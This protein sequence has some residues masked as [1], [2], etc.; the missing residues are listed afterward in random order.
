[1]SLGK[2]YARAVFKTTSSAARRT[3]RMMELTLGDPE[4]NRLRCVLWN[5]YI[6]QYMEFVTEN[7]GV[8]VYVIFQLYRP[9]RYQ[10]TLSVSSSF[11]M[12]KLIINGRSSEFTE[13]QSEFPADGDDSVTATTITL[14]SNGDGSREDV[15]AGQAV[16]QQPSPII[17][18]C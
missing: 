14:S 12:S 13:F 6:D 2:S 5:K 7:V 4:G 1:M 11:D 8:P 15:L 17:L 10:G 18:F 3:E 9:K 16:R